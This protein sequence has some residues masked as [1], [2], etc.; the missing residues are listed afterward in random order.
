MWLVESG[1]AKILSVPHIKADGFTVDY[2]NKCDWVVTTPEGE[3]P[4]L[5]K[6][7]VS[8]RD[9]LFF[10][11]LSI[12]LVTFAVYFENKYRQWKL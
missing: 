2:K 9:L 11:G 4:C 1:I 5:R 3:K 7:Q 6:T 12:G 8:A 10:D